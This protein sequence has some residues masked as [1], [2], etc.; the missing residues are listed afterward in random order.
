VGCGTVFKLTPGGTLTTL[1]SFCSQPNCTDGAIPLAGLVQGADGSFYGMTWAG[2]DY[3][4]CS[5]WGCGTVFKITPSGTLTTLHTFCSQ[6]GGSCT[7]GYEP[8]GV[9]VQDVDGSL[10]GT[11]SLGGTGRFALGTV[12]KITLAGTLTTLQTIDGPDGQDPDTGLA[13]V[14]NGDLYGT[15]L[16]GSGLHGFGGSIFK[17]TQAGQLNTVHLFDSSSGDTY[18]PSVPVQAT[19][20]AI[21][22]TTVYGGTSSACYDGCGMIYSL[23]SGLG[24]FVETLPTARKVGDQ[25]RILGTYLAGATS[26]TFNG[27]L[28]NFT[29]LSP[30]QIQATVP[31]GATTGPVQVVTPSGTLRS[32][33][34]FRVIQ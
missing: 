8:R 33:V 5:G 2:G 28:A 24:P 21:Y 9:L 13:Q 12:F 31:S 22:G 25:V 29:V 3:T 20:G 6:G 14:S 16:Y 18:E 26:V 32:N 7:D 17:I 15:T 19:N 11:T 27:L 1:Y 10:Y 34:P 4:V 30:S 23:D